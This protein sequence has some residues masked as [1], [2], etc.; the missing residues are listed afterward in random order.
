[1]IKKL[2][3]TIIGISFCFS[4]CFG[5]QGEEGGDTTCTPE[6]KKCDSNEVYKCDSG[7]K[8]WVFYKACEDQVCSNGSCTS[9][10]DGDIDFDTENAI[11]SDSEIL[12]DGDVEESAND[13]DVDDNTDGDQ[14]EIDDDYDSDMESSD[15]DDAEHDTEIDLIDGD[16]DLVEQS[17]AEQEQVQH[18][19]SWTLPDVISAQSGLSGI[20]YIEAYEWSGQYVSIRFPEELPEWIETSIT[21]DYRMKFDFAVPEDA[22]VGDTELKII[23]CTLSNEC[24]ERSFIFRIHPWP[25][26][27]IGSCDNP[28]EIGGNEI[29]FFASDVTSRYYGIPEGC[30]NANCREKAAS[31]VFKLKANRMTRV[32]NEDSIA[33]NTYVTNNCGDANPVCSSAIQSYTSSIFVEKGLIDSSLLVVNHTLIS[34]LPEHVGKIQTTPIYEDVIEGDKCEWFDQTQLKHGTVLTDSL[35]GFTHDFVYQPEKWTYCR[36]VENEIK[37]F[38][39]PDKFYRLFFNTTEKLII[40]VEPIDD[41]DP[42]I[43]VFRGCDR[44]DKLSYCKA[45]SNTNGKGVAERLY[46]GLEVEKQAEYILMVGSKDELTNEGRYKLSIDATECVVQRSDPTLEPI[47]IPDN[48]NSLHA[49]LMTEK[50]FYGYDD[51]P[52]L[53]IN[54]Y[55]P[56]R[57]E[58]TVYATHYIGVNLFPIHDMEGSGPIEQI[59]INYRLDHIDP[60][61]SAG[62]NIKIFDR[63]EGNTGFLYSVMGIKNEEQCGGLPCRYQQDCPPEYTCSDEHICE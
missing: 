60:G 14:V 46:Y 15:G 57:E 50:T 20:V 63:S 13:G 4:F 61:Y 49:A 59:D 52:R 25:T 17:E 9:V 22:D 27:L 43:V 54:L 55:H 47:P 2:L 6:A 8:S 42:V 7:G 16:D 23:A 33:H 28:Y 45:I 62:W 56:N 31:T 26:E 1:M 39:G 35:K 30:Y 44:M 37:D 38:V 48:S 41:F 58:I 34:I 29:R 12:Q 5:C 3:F 53:I 36:D 11:E 32:Y 10:G 40:E 21:N 24:E 51:N 19:L 18:M